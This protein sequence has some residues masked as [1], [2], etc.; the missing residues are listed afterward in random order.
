MNIYTLFRTDYYVDE[1]GKP[2]ILLFSRDVNRQPAVFDVPFSPYFYVLEEEEIPE[3]VKKYVEKVE[4]GYTAFDGRKV[5]KIYV[6]VVEKDLP[7]IMEEMRKAFSKTYESHIFLT[8]RFLIDNGIKSTFINDNGVLYPIDETTL[9]KVINIKPRNLYIDIEALIRDQIDIDNPQPILCITVYDNYTNLLTSFVVD[10]TKTS[11]TTR[12]VRFNDKLY[13]QVI[14]RFRDEK[15]MLNAF[16]KF[17][18]EINPD[19]IIG[20]NSSGMFNPVEKMFFSGFDLPYLI[21]RCRLLKLPIEKI[22]PLKQ[23]FIERKIN[24]PVVR[25]VNLIDLLYTL[26]IMLGGKELV[27]WKLDEVYANYFGLKISKPLNYDNIDELLNKNTM[28]VIKIVELDN[29]LEIT[30]YIDWRRRIV[31]CCY[32]DVFIASRIFYILALREKPNPLPDKSEMPKLT[33]EGAYVKEPPIGIQRNVAVFDIKMAYPTIIESLNIS[34]DTLNF[35]ERGNRVRIKLDGKYVD[36]YFDYETEGLLPKVIKRLKKGRL[37]LKQKIKET[38]DVEL[39]K[40]YVIEDKCYKSIINAMYGVFGSKTFG[41]YNPYVAGAITSAVK[42]ILIELEKVLKEMGINVLYIDTDGIYIQLESIEKA[43]ELEQTIN[44][45]IRKY[46]DYRW[47]VNTYLEAEFTEFYKWILFIKT[48]EEEKGSKKNFIGKVIWKAGIECDEITT[49]GKIMRETTYSKF[50]V[51]LQRKIV[52]LID[53]GETD[54]ILRVINDAISQLENYDLDYIGIPRAIHLENY[55]VKQAHVRG[56]EYSI[57]HF[58]HPKVMLGTKV[59]Y[60]YVRNLPDTDV[61]AWE[62]VSYIPKDKI[63]IDRTK[64]IDRLVWKPLKNIL[65]AL[66][67]KQTLE[68]YIGDTLV[69]GQKQN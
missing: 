33:Y 2:H 1:T 44:T 69:F 67:G 15:S 31:G 60:V 63:R 53:R 55:Q 45:L 52:E 18:E 39:R 40:K 10:K 59:K 9:G 3:K 17:V 38:T 14:M 8:R 34:N 42:E 65:D 19:N 48:A 25:G 13:T 22:S 64:M 46:M 62:D 6:K 57:K 24:R 12:R 28:D 26:Q 35:D 23:V 7:E 4:T 43:K 49:T 58:G 30:D 11:A 32:D 51:D 16:I 5:K 61:I 20:Y 68:Q 50:T 56:I 29:Y 27:S 54:K 36:V 66:E 21:S 47:K 41:L 37:E